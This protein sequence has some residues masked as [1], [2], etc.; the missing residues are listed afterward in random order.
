MSSSRFNALLA[1]GVTA[2][3]LVACAGA[4]RKA[5]QVPDAPAAR[6]LDVPEIAARTQRAPFNVVATTPEGPLPERSSYDDDDAAR[7]GEVAITFNRPMAAL[8]A[9]GEAVPN[10]AEVRSAEGQVV[11]GKWRWL[12]TRTAIFTAR[13]RLQYATNYEVIMN[14]EI[15]AFDGELMAEPQANNFKF[16]TP[17]VRVRNIGAN[18]RHALRPGA[19]FHIE[20][21]QPVDLKMLAAHTS[22]E[23]GKKKIAVRATRDPNDKLNLQR[24]ILTPLSKLPLN[25]KVTVVV[26]A[27]LRGI[28]GTLTALE[29]EKAEFETYAPVKAKL[30][31]S[32]SSD[33]DTSCEPDGS[34]WM[35]F[36]NDVDED[37]FRAAVRVNGKPVA[38]SQRD[39][40]TS[41]R[42]TDFANVPARTSPRASYVISLVGPLKDEYGQNY[43]GP[44][45]FTLRTRDY[46]PSIVIGARSGV[47]EAERPASTRSLKIMALNVPNYEVDVALMSEEDAA[48][49]QFSRD[50]T[51]QWT[52]YRKVRTTAPVNKSDTQKFSV[53]ELLAPKGGRGLVGIRVRYSVNGKPQSQQEWLRV[54]DL[55]LSSKI[56]VYGGEIWT[57][58]L[59]TAKPYPNVAV[60]LMLAGAE[61]WRGSSSAE[62]KLLVPAEQV[63][64]CKDKQCVLLAAA[65]K[66]AETQPLWPE[67]AYGTPWPEKFPDE[68]SA[69]LFTERDLYKRGETVRVK[70]VVREVTKS[71]N[72]VKPG[73][74]YEVTAELQGGE[75]DSADPLLKAELK[76][77]A[78]GELAFDVPVP[79]SAP[80]GDLRV[81]LKGHD[82]EATQAV[83]VSTYR[84]AAFKAVVDAETPSAMP[85]ETMSFVARGNYLFGGPMNGVK[86][87]LRASWGSSWFTPPGATEAELFVS[88]SA[89]VDD[90]VN[91]DEPS[92]ELSSQ[93]VELNERGEYRL[94]VKAPASKRGVPMS[95]MVEADVE[96]LTRQHGAGEASAIVHP[97]DFY[98]AMKQLSSSV[99]APKKSF[100]TEVAALKP[101]G[102]RQASVRAKVEL[103]RREWVSVTEDHGDLGVSRS[104]HFKDTSVG[105]CNVVTTGGLVSCDLTPTRAGQYALRASAKDSKGRDS[106]VSTTLYV[107]GDD[108]GAF[109]NDT[110]REI[111]LI[112]DKKDYKPGDKAAIFVRMPYAESDAIVSVERSGVYTSF[113]THLAG[114]MPRV[115]VP[116]GADMGASTYVVVELLRGRTGE[117]AGPDIRAPEARYGHLQLPIDVSAHQLVVSVEGARPGYS[118]GEDVELDVKVSN[119]SGKAE[120]A[121]LTVYAVDEGVL[122][123]SGYK[124]PDLLEHFVRK[125]GYHVENGDTRDGLAALFDPYDPS[126]RDK[127]EDGGGGGDD[128]PSGV[129]KDFRSTVFFSPDLV[130]D[131]SGRAHVKF[132][133]PDGLTTYRLMAVAMTADDK[134]GGT[135][136]P[137]VVSKK[138]M[139]RSA[140][141]RY[142]YADDQVRAGVVVT[143]T[144]N[145]EI[146]VSVKAS[147]DGARL[148]GDITKTVRI[149]PKGQSEVIWPYMMNRAGTAKFRFEIEGG[150]ESDKVE[151]SIDVRTPLVPETVALYNETDG[152]VRES[153]ASLGALRP[154]YGGVELSV[155]SGPIVGLKDALTGVWDYPYGCSEQLTTKVLSTF[156]AEDL[157]KR[158]GIE[159]PAN[160]RS[161]AED[162]VQ[163]VL[164]RQG[165]D[166]GFGW[167]GQNEHLDCR[168]TA[169]VTYGLYE[170][171][172]HGVLVPSDALERGTS[173]LRSRCQNV[174]GKKDAWNDNYS[175][176]V[177][178]SDMLAEV[179]AANP[180]ALTAYYQS[181]AKLSLQEVALL[182]HA[183]KI[184]KMGDAQVQTLQKML[185]A[186]LKPG[187]SGTARHAKDNRWTWYA[188]AETAQLLRALVK[189]DPD[190]PM[191]GQT[192]K[193]L[194]SE[195]E[196]GAWRNTHATAWSLMA[197]RD[198]AE[199]LHL[200]ESKMRAE[201]FVGTALLLDVNFMP[202][203]A[204]EARAKLAM[205]ELIKQDLT[206]GLTVRA[207]GGRVYTAASLHYAR[208]ELPKMPVESGMFLEGRMGRIGRKSLAGDVIPVFPAPTVTSLAAGDLV[209]ID[210]DVTSD[211]DVEQT[212][213]VVP[214]PAGLEA[215]RADL[216]GEAG[217]VLGLGFGESPSS[218]DDHEVRWF[219]SLEAGVRHFRVL[220]RATTRGRFVVPPMRA[221]SM[222]NPD[223]FGRTAGGLLEVK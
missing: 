105:S 150:G 213:V 111:T 198:A 209:A 49:M 44:R 3:I 197:L 46:S 60:R 87:H 135:D 178:S 190:H 91:Q 110:Q 47:L 183:M 74:T 215:V 2:S 40:S 4:L 59:S 125:A 56:S 119:S 30:S 217:S 130:T 34:F 133:L 85:G 136:A 149:P 187:A 11:D 61:L 171:R 90:D 191:L 17:P 62:G 8:G 18:D 39:A 189:L 201:G 194:L 98:M 29:P 122:M 158:L 132:K 108:D 54:T 162:A 176:S 121:N 50:Q 81:T 36:N 222:Y 147:V 157:K 14:P 28:E 99:F 38:W 186:T 65:G 123:L 103:L 71:G 68:R 155:A 94:T 55:A 112:S 151:V 83:R 218:Y 180:G 58:R 181:R 107:W 24:A 52:P 165:N 174:P 179:G 120:R 143:S 5:T 200:G 89:R 100:R 195:R 216:Q 45:S 64:A 86:A 164:T 33:V 22:I 118:P 78:F 41:I 142:A 223:V 156:A 193:L 79:K 25:S 75:S 159:V 202:G 144:M 27:G 53:D 37:Q 173:V 167:Y 139:A 192:V 124:R 188:D 92:S 26:D 172:K 76:T 199:A 16:S 163:T 31:C 131:T 141:P 42:W 72:R 203:Q 185:E 114:A 63:K 57:S 82:I 166:G 154:E 212:V 95:V 152:V 88:D 140:L 35:S 113:R 77:G 69:L 208:K 43:A 13:P 175:D 93:D 177:F 73:E 15:R 84:P 127:G 182:A 221:E 206:R 134:Y 170:A 129:R 12:G 138:L 23:V 211:Q 10:V 102:S 115:E 219:T 7:A 146:S 96:D 67:H 101:D 128:G 126:R 160:A 220:A 210:V 20:L 148:E 6:A 214:I 153:M 104:S 48:R 145:R 205:P 51:T 184:A 70:G 66:D 116:I 80:L 9:A 204:A 161:L 106:V 97:A 109:G 137:L 32:G 21:S 169:Y 207:T 168:L 1:T 196:H 117:G 19:T